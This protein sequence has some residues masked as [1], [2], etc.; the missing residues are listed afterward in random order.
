VDTSAFVE[1]AKG[2]RTREATQNHSRGCECLATQP[3][4]GRPG[5]ENLRVEPK[6]HSSN[7]GV[8]LEA[9]HH[10]GCDGMDPTSLQG[11]QASTECRELRGRELR[12]RTSGDRE[13]YAEFAKRP[14]PSGEHVQHPRPSGEFAKRPRPSGEQIALR[15][16]EREAGGWSTEG[17]GSGS[18]SE[19]TGSWRTPQGE[20]A[21]R[22]GPSVE[23]SET[24]VSRM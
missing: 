3:R 19:G 8:E 18:R 7:D 21:S 12:N 13:A 6:D 4:R 23:A 24:K 15:A 1:A 11:K 20:Q 10:R 22:S 5:E 16:T 17:E 14:R 9:D 2:R